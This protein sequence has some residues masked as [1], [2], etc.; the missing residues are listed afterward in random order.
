M[1]LLAAACPVIGLG[2]GAGG[3]FPTAW[4]WGAL[5]FG[6]LA[7][8]ALVLRPQVGLDRRGAAGLAAVAALVAWIALSAS[9]ARDAPAAVLEA[10]RAVLYLLGFAAVLLGVGRGRLG[11]L[12]GG[13]LAGVTVVCAVAL[14]TRLVPGPGEGVRPIVLNR[15]TDP[16]GYWNALGLLAAM[17]VILGLVLAARLRHPAA[18]AL[19]AATVPVVVTTLYFTYSRGAWVALGAG[20]LLAVAADPRRLQLL[21]HVLALGALAAAGVWIAS[22]QE[23]LTRLT[24]A[25]ALIEDEGRHMIGVLAALVA[26]S[27]VAALVLSGAERRIPAPGPRARRTVELGLLAAA[28]VA[29]VTAVAAYGG[30]GPMA[31]RAYD[32]F[33]DEPVRASGEAEDLNRRLFRLYGEGRLELWR[34]A[35]RDARDHPVAGAGAGGFEEHYL[36]TRPD[37]SKVRDAHNLYVETVE[38]LGW[39]GGVL[40]ALAVGIPLAAAWRARRHPLGVAALGV[41]VA[42]LVEAAVDWMWEMAL[43]TLVA[44]ACGAMLLVAAGEE[45]AAPGAPRRRLPRALAVAAVLALVALMLPGLVGHRAAAAAGRALEEGRWAT[46]RAEARTA[47]RWTPW[48]ASGHQARGNAEA[49]LG[50]FDAARR[51]LREAARRDPG[52]WRIWFDLGNASRGAERIAAWRR[53]ARLNPLEEDVRV[54]RPQLDRAEVR[55]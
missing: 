54:I 38:E 13:L 41:L 50:R 32:A 9:W 15:L 39:V 46:A 10:E 7:V 29:L 43:L 53:A 49:G 34:I 47:I 6:W 35:W 21:G 30:P 45:P 5:W 27:A 20:L 4:G 33:K 25:P 52:D 12:A 55:R 1:V 31:E 28:A 26:T 23:A 48:S 51:D 22:D 11:A 3:Y 16:V 18:R 8:L 17:G 36:R 24:A 42:Y 14:S 19:S 2:L 37:A 44:L 40:L